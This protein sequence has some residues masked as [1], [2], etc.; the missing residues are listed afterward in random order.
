MSD[1]PLRLVITGHVDHGKSTVTGRLLADTHALPDGKLEAIRAYCERNGK[2]FEYAFLLDAL[3]DERAQGITIDAARIHFNTGKRRCVLLDTPGHIEFLR[4]MVTGAARAD[5]AVLVIDAAEGVRENSRRHGYLLSFLGIRQIVVVVNKMDLV[6]RDR[7]VYDAIVAEYSRFLEQVGLAADGYIPAVATEGDNLARRSDAMPWYDGP[8]LLDTLDR[9]APK[10][11]PRDLPFRMPVQDIYRFSRHND[12]RRIVAGS[13]LSGHIA[14]GDE[15]LF[16]PSNKR[17]FVATLESF[18]GPAPERYGTGD[19]AG[20]TMTEQIYITRGELAAKAGERPPEVGDRFRA[21]IFWLGKEPLRTEREYLLKIG[22]AKCPVRIERVLR[23]MN[24]ATLDEGTGTTVACNEAAECVLRTARP[25]AFD[26]AA[27]GE[28]TARFVMVDDHDIRGGGIILEALESAPR[29]R[30]DRIMTRNYKWAAGKI[31]RDLRAE[32][33]GHRPHLVI[34]TGAKDAGKKAVA[35]EL[36]RRLFDEG[37]L[38]FFMGIANLLYGVDADIQGAPGNR[39]EHLRRLAELA[40]LLLDAGHILI[41][42]AVELTDADRA[43]IEQAVPREQTFVVW[44][45]GD[46]PGAA[47]ADIRFPALPEPS[48]TARRIGAALGEKGILFDR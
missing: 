38:A 3:K 11:A 42:T 9:F 41:V 7:A 48:D 37:R 21:S 32:R 10:S 36:E 35:R 17:S 44:L 6:G 28:L 30:Y 12:L 20:F 8:T 45:G 25:I 19:A 46:G 26:T 14:P 5:A 43:L 24:A 13:V 22:A 18:P 29:E 33:H 16:Y 23:T 40:N 27:A 2:P 34:V 39:E 15:V 31:D 47:T 4:N 1:A